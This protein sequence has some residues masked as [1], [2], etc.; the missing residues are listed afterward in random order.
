[1]LQVIANLDQANAELDGAGD[2]ARGGG[3]WLTGAHIKKSN[4]QIGTSVSIDH[5]AAQQIGKLT[6]FPSLE[7]TAEKAV[8]QIGGCDSGYSCQY[9]YNISWRSTTTPNAPEA[10]PRL[11]FE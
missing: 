10:N 5:V 6:R 7:L 11:V 8:R 4:D 2:H 9:E 1:K 3:V